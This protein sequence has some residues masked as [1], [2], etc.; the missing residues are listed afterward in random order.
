MDKQVEER[1]G[2]RLSVARRRILSS[3]DGSLNKVLQGDPRMMTKN[4][5][6]NSTCGSD[7]SLVGNRKVGPS[8]ASVFHSRDR[9]VLGSA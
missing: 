5:Y 2:A 9:N 3:P 8:L 6:V 4:N 7:S 1:R